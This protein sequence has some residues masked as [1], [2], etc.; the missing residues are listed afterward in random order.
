ML[1]HYSFNAII[2]N[3]TYLSQNLYQL[4]DIRDR[5]QPVII[6]S[7]LRDFRDNSEN[8]QKILDAAAIERHIKNID[9]LGQEKTLQKI[10]KEFDDD[11]L[12]HRL[13]K[14]V[15][16]ASF[17]LQ[18]LSELKFD[19]RLSGSCSQLIGYEKLPPRRYILPHRLRTQRRSEPAP[20]RVLS[21]RYQ[22]EPATRQPPVVHDPVR[23]YASFLPLRSDTWPR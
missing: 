15:F 20:T 16:R 10:W 17:Q 5:S 13:K 6:D 21:P 9:S 23:A 22:R 7:R 12:R 19:V 1:F 14:C 3:R 8:A 4:L 18:I 2:L 11:L